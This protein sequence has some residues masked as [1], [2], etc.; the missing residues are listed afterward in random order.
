M[1]SKLCFACVAGKRG[2]IARSRR[3]KQSFGD[4]CVPKQELA[5]RGA[6]ESTVQ[7]PFHVPYSY[8]SPRLHRAGTPRPVPARRQPAAP[9]LSPLV[10][11]VSAALW[12]RSSRRDSVSHSANEYRTRAPEALPPATET[13]FRRTDPFPK[14]CAN[15]GNEMANGPWSRWPTTCAASTASEP[16]SKPRQ[17]RPEAAPTKQDCARCRFARPPDLLPTHPPRKNRAKHGVREKNADRTS[18]IPSFR[19]LGICIRARRTRNGQTGERRRGVRGSGPHG[20]SPDSRLLHT[21]FAPASAGRTSAFPP[22]AVHAL[23]HLC[24]D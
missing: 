4:K 3:A 17:Q 5:E 23:L 8:A 13:E 11:K 22:P 9:P 20:A 7:H 19:L 6:P 2:A 12:E 18:L 10:P 15:F 24:T 1:S 21:E 14:R 16:S